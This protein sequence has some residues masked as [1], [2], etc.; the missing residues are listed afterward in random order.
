[1][2]DEPVQQDTFIEEAGTLDLTVPAYVLFTLLSC[3]CT[4]FVNSNH[5]GYLEG[6]GRYRSGSFL[7]TILFGVNIPVTIIAVVIIVLK[8]ETVLKRSSQLKKCALIAF[9]ITALGAQVSFFLFAK[10]GYK[11]F[12][13][14]FGERVKANFMLDSAGRQW[15]K[16]QSI[17]KTNKIMHYDEW[18]QSVQSA[19][20]GI[21]APW[22]HVKNWKLSFETPPCARFTLDNG[23]FSIRRGLAICLDSGNPPTSNQGEY[24][25]PINGEIFVFTRIHE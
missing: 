17:S 20:K 2:T 18:P 14:G 6:L 3:G 4:A 21:T 15:L 8:T 10:P 16:T 12:T 24:R 11:V 22:E 5:F 19:I 7:D 1:M 23:T 25:I 13:D 9:L